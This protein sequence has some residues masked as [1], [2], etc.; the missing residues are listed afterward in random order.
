MY[1]Q[2]SPIGA[3]A[4]TTLITSDNV[5]TL[6]DF[7]WHWFFSLQVVW[8]DYHS[9]SYDL[10]AFARS[11]DKEKELIEAMKSF[12]NNIDILFQ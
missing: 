2:N 3:A 8:D 9:E 12:A 5:H 4:A 1:N 11:I 6:P 10:L 7:D